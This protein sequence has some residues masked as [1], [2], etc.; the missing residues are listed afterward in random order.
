MEQPNVDGSPQISI[1]IPTRNGEKTISTLLESVMKLDYEKEKLEVIV[2]DGYSTDRTIELVSEYPVELVMEDGHGLNAARNTGIK[3][4]SGEILSFTDC[5]CVVPKNWV[6]K[7]VKNF[8]D[9]KTGCVGGTVLGC[10]ADTFSS[11]YANET[12]FR[13]MPSFKTRVVTENIHTLLYPAGCNMSFRRSVLDKI[14]PFNEDI[15]Y[16]F[17]EMELVERVGEAGYN[18][19]LD[20]EVLIYHRHRETIEEILKQIFGYARGSILLIKERGI[21]NRIG[22][23]LAL[24]MFG[25]IVGFSL[26]GLLI[27]LYLLTSNTL[28]MQVF[29]LLVFAPF[30]LAMVRYALKAL[31]T[32]NYLS[33]F[34]YPFIDALRI[35]AF[36]LGQW[37]QLFSRKPT[38]DM[39]KSRRVPQTEIAL[40]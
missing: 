24:D 30:L 27:M 21:R 36:S 1:I 9:P 8:N 25:F 38:Y 4:S 7:I 34:T 6:R 12:L 14:G 15:R 19:T 40:N 11:R 18:T 31:K 16:G 37:Y 5:D 20:P 2:V 22:F 33:I 3:H 39:R 32:K 29:L 26:F 10:D 13:I 35:I 28:F 23:L 17:D